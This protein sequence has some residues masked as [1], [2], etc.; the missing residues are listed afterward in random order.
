MTLRTSPHRLPPPSSVTPTSLSSWDT[1]AWT[2]PSKP[3]TCSTRAWDHLS[4]HVCAQRTTSSTPLCLILSLLLPNTN[5][6]TNLRRTRADEGPQATL[7]SHPQQLHSRGRVLF[8][9]AP[10]AVDTQEAERVTG[11]L[12]RGLESSLAS[13]LPCCHRNRWAKHRDACPPE[14][15]EGLPKSGWE[16]T[17]CSAVWAGARSTALG[18]SIY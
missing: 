8:L 18:Y 14:A 2:L 1:A 12:A 10:A 11:E 7:A 6:V 4:S 13:S 16:W 15:Q 17:E 9:P 5:H 3:F